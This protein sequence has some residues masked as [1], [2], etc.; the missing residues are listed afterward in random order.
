MGIDLKQKFNWIFFFTLIVGI[1]SPTLHAQPGWQDFTARYYYSI[2][3][4]NGNE[5]LFKKNKEY[6]LIINNVFYQSPNIPTDSLKRVLPNSSSKFENYIRINDLSL[7]IPQNHNT[8]RLLEIKIIHQKD[9]LYL[10]QA[11]GKGSGFDL[12]ISSK[13]TKTAS[14][15]TLQFIPGHYY[16]PN[17]AKM[18]LENMPEA[19]GSVKIMNASQRNF[20]ITKDLYESLSYR[21]SN[22]ETTTKADEL[23][24]S[25]FSKG[26][27]TITKEIEPTKIDKAVLPYS[28][29]YIEGDLHPTKDK[30]LYFGLANYSLD[31]SRCSSSKKVFSLLNKNDNTIRLWFPKDNPRLFSSDNLYIDSFNNIL[32]QTVWIKKSFDS[33]QSDCSDNFPSTGFIYSS[34]DDGQTWK[35]NKKLTTL[36]F[37]QYKLRKLEFLDKEYALGFTLQTK[38]H[39]KKKYDFQQ[40][41]YY[42]FKNM[43]VV[44]S[45]KTPDDLHYNSNY[46]AYAFAIKND[47]ISLGP[48]NFDEYPTSGKPYFQPIITKANHQWHFEVKKEMYF[49]PTPKIE[50]ETIK[51]YQNFQLLNSRK[52]V[53]KNGSGSLKLGND[54]ADNP[55]DKGFYVIEKGNQIYLLHNSSNND[56]GVFISFDGGTSWYIYPKALDEDANYKFLEID[57]QNRISFFNQ[58]KLFKAFYKFSTE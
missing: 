30:N 33:Q 28:K 10:N 8:D 58:W 26:H 20:L 41:V 43:K 15:F 54:V 57:N 27:F 44:D 56:T 38:E 52:L 12:Y 39:S 22:Y 48:W 16:F 40:G 42:L 7:R 32:Y 47:T 11:T 4:N 3:D 49:K 55:S 13:E 29:P 23:V 6:S 37:D 5:I 46:N 21:N 17:W 53:F 9:T 31:M 19:N 50:K 25:N 51:Q 1:L 24:Q 36:Y 2:L 34:T 14:D 18:L 35:E 45:L